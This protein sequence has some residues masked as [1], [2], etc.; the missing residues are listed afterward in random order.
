MAPYQL[1][2]KLVRPF[3]KTSEAWWGIPVVTATQETE[4]G[5][6]QGRAIQGKISGITYQKNKLKAKGFGE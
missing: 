5:G 1:G 3:S 6:S 4:V 2:E